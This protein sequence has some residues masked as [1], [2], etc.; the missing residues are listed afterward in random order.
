MRRRAAHCASHLPGLVCGHLRCAITVHPA[1]R[2]NTHEKAVQT[3]RVTESIRA[4]VSRSGGRGRTD[5]R[6]CRRQRLGVRLPT[7]SAS[8][9]PSGSGARCPVPAAE[10]PVVPPTVVQPVVT[11]VTGT[12]VRWLRTYRTLSVR[13]SCGLPG[14]VAV[15]RHG[16][17]IGRNTFICPA[18]RATTV[19]VR[20][21][22]A[23]N[24]SLRVGAIVRARVVSG[25]H[26]HSKF[27]RVVRPVRSTNV[28]QT[29]DQPQD[30]V[31][32]LMRQR[33]GHHEQDRAY[34]A[35]LLLVVRDDVLRVRV[36]R[37]ASC[38]LVGLLFL[39]RLQLGVLRRV[40]YEPR[41]RMLALVERRQSPA[42]RPVLSS[43]A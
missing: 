12:T 26:R 39:E 4:P 32:I 37:H 16:L 43:I 1:A 34:L 30:V 15:F 21:T 28:A 23:A 8:P 19:R 35:H 25:A 18:S 36:L 2:G 27:L 13:V 11:K 41:R 9:Y 20:I 33:L 5:V 22:R 31:R 17:R 3:A 42:L 10:T 14:T 38:Q 6:L 24:R 40:D 7:P 29:A